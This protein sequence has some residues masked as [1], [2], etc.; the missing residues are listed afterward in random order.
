[1]QGR[2]LHRAGLGSGRRCAGWV[3]G[4]AP[5]LFS[6]KALLNKVRSKNRLD[7]SRAGSIPPTSGP[8]AGAQK[9]TQP[10]RPRAGS[11]H[12][13][14][15][16]G[17]SIPLAVSLTG[18]SR[19]DVTQLLPLLD[20]ILAVPG[21]VSRPR[22]LPD[23]LFADRAYDHLKY[24]RLLRQRGIRPAIA[25]GG[26]LHGT[27]LGTFRWVVERTM[28]WLHGFRR[29]RIRW[30]RRDDIHEVSLGLAVCLVTC[31]HVQTHCQGQ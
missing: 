21:A 9:R 13:M 25:E 2:R 4:H 15:T 6:N 3:F 24:R 27:G 10:G 31:R 30:Q 26:Q 29:L 18:G 1:M 8:H 22:R 7:R 5:S 17:Q 11:K 19:K 14:I 20:K 28:S 12:H 23:M 16:D